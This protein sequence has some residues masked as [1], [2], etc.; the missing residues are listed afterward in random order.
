MDDKLMQCLALATS[1]ISAVAAVLAFLERGWKSTIRATLFVLG[2]AGLTYIGLITQRNGTVGS[3][4]GGLLPKWAAHQTPRAAPGSP[5]VLPLASIASPPPAVAQSPSAPGYARSVSGDPPATASPVPCIPSAES[6]ISNLPPASL[7][8]HDVHV[9]PLPVPSF[10]LPAGT[11]KPLPSRYPSVYWPAEVLECPNCHTPFSSSP[12]YSRGVKCPVCSQIVDL[13]SPGRYFTIHCCC[14]NWIKSPFKY[15]EIGATG[16][17]LQI[18]YC[19]PRCRAQG[20]IVKSLS[21]TAVSPLS[22]TGAN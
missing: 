13:V 4:N 8:P 14:G 10:L 1:L 2:L 11:P 18:P 5:I 3:P 7:T 21:A 20:T 6:S 12:A 16:T 17:N 19:C 15:P 22:A 9:R